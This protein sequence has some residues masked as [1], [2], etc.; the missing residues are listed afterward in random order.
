M[1]AYTRPNRRTYPRAERSHHQIKRAAYLEPCTV[2]HHPLRRH[3]LLDGKRVCARP[4]ATD[5]VPGLRRDVRA[6]AR[7]VHDEGAGPDPG[8]TAAARPEAACNLPTGSVNLGGCSGGDGWEL[9]R[10][11]VLLRFVRESAR[12]GF[13]GGIVYWYAAAQL[14]SPGVYFQNVAVAGVAAVVLIA[15]GRHLRR[16]GRYPFLPRPEGPVRIEDQLVEMPPSKTARPT[17]WFSLVLGWFM[18]VG[19]IINLLAAFRAVAS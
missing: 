5:L 16:T 10:L 12:S 9:K 13:W 8:L 11:D 3:A 14:A 18:A 2:C 7:R 19:A 4:G 15:L 17:G 6:D 1:R